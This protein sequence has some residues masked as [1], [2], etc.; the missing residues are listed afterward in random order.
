MRSLTNKIIVI[1][2]LALALGK[3]SIAFAVNEPKAPLIISAPDHIGKEIIE[4]DIKRGKALQ[5]KDF[6]LMNHL[7]D[8][9]WVYILPN[10]LL[11]DKHHYFEAIKDIDYKNV[12]YDSYVARVY[13]DTVILNLRAYI[14]AIATN[15][16]IDESLAYTR[17]YIKKEGE[18]KFVSQQ[19][20][21]IK[22]KLGD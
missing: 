17:V 3:C 4:L 16:H 20:T 2:L 14:T 18:W 7:Y 9:N 5:D 8:E 12:I 11:V 15:L 10:G 1:A 13:G 6:V 19:S 21:P 22:E